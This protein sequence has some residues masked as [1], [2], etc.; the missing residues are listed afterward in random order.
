MDSEPVRAS[1][2]AAYALGM[3]FTQPSTE[4]ALQQLRRVAVTPRARARAVKMLRD[5]SVVDPELQQ[6]A[7]DLLDALE[8]GS[9]RGLRSPSVDRMSG[10]N[11][12]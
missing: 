11:V 5:R 10:R 1:W 7:V 12:P 6:R 2:L 8:L 4:L 3:A 9:C